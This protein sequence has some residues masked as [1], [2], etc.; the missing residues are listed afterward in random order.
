M[1]FGHIKTLAVRNKLISKLYQHFRERGLPYG[2]QDALS[3]LSP[4]CSSP[5]QQLRHG[6]KTRLGWVANPYP[7][8]TFTLQDAPSFA[9]RDDVGDEPR[10]TATGRSGSEG[11]ERSSGGLDHLVRRRAS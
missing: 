3:T 10:L 11:R 8:G 4:S 1:G 2:L 5:S 9:Q 6:P 7:T